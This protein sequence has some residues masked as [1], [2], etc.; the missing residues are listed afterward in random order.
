EANTDSQ[1]TLYL[2]GKGGNLGISGTEMKGVRVIV[3]WEKPK[4]KIDSWLVFND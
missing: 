1:Y 3:S 4:D 2:L